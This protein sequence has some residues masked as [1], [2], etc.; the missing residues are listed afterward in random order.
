MAPR[1]P[2][3][4]PIEIIDVS[5]AYELDSTKVNV[6]GSFITDCQRLNIRLYIVCSPYYEKYTGTDY[7]L[8]TIKKIAAANKVN[9]FNFSQQKLFLE[10][11]KLFAN[12]WHLKD[13][14]ARVFSNILIDKIEL[15]ERSGIDSI[16]K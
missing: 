12:A 14:G 4:T 16:I 7:S 15:A 3:T 1:K 10:S 13:T 11:P 9:F 6:L 2:I 5:K 8:L